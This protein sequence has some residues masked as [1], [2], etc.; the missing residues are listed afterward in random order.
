MRD[1]RDRIVFI[2]LA[3]AAVAVMIGL[4]GSLGQFSLTKSVEASILGPTARHTG[5]PGEANCTACHGEFPV[6]SGTGNVQI[7]GLP[8]N[9]R[10]GQQVPVTVTLS[11][12]DAV[13]YGFQLTA[14]DN[15]GRR[16]GSFT[17]PTQDPM[18]MRIR[19]GT[20][21]GNERDYVSHTVEGTSSTVFGTRSWTFT[22]NAPQMRG[23]KVRFYAAG[24]AANS[25]G[26]PNGDYIYTTSAATL[27]GSA[28]SNFDGDVS[29]DVAVFR[30]S[31]GVWYSLNSSDGGFRAVQ[32][33]IPG[34]QIVPGD[35]DGDGV[36]DIAVWRPSTG[37]WYVNLSSG[38][39]S[40]LQFG[41]AGDVP[42]PGDYD[43]D[44][45][46]DFAV[47]RP[48]TG[49]WYIFRSSDGS[50]DIRQFG[51]G[52]D[53]ATQADFDGDGRTDVAV[54]RPSEGTWYIWRSSDNAVSIFQFGSPGDRPVPGDYDGD[55]IA[56][57]AVWRPSDGVWYLLMS[58][59][60]FGA[61]QFGIPTDR[62]APAD[63]DGDGSTDPA[64]FRDGVW[65]ILR[66]SDGGFDVASF[67]LAGDIPVPSGYI[68]E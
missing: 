65:Y 32:F 22:W 53:K 23:G 67:G 8:A 52:T 10:A 45:K 36:T 31:S 2:K 55:G 12:F 64:V 48:S 35:Y 15:L 58:S 3:V 54:F 16:I 39:F 6:N 17:L 57:A 5:A 51:I 50:F 7:F 63:F 43:G 4:V 60:G 24:N 42:V 11:Q 41:T 9:Y 18:E 21:D 38:G 19:T 44:L 49:V 27:S 34:D 26:G 30:P 66:S 20:V 1:F 59:R 14:I 61:V 46:S 68:A 29:S 33:G 37:V 40:I 56:D 25:D 28:I 13:N 47:W 62:P